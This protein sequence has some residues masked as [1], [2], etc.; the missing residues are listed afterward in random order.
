MYEEI[1]KGLN[2]IMKD[3]HQLILEIFGEAEL[4]VDLN[5]VLECYDSA[6][7]NKTLKDILDETKE[8]RFDEQTFMMST[9]A[10]LHY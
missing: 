1:T 3:I 2:V 6:D 5:D 4:S 10:Y 9:R 8:C 7:G